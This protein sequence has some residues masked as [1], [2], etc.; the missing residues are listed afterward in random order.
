MHRRLGQPLHA[1]GRLAA[2]LKGRRIEALGEQHVAHVLE[3]DVLVPVRLDA[4]HPQPQGGAGRL[5]RRR[6]ERIRSPRVPDPKRLAREHYVGA[7]TLTM[8]ASA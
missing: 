4:R 2:G 7:R 1:W 5:W 6:V 3:G 8:A